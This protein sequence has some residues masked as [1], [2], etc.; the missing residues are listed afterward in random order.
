MEKILKMS[1]LVALVLMVGMI[2]VNIV[3]RYLFSVTY[4]IT[5][6]WPVWLMIWCVF[7]YIG[8]NV[9]ENGHLA[10]DIVPNR[11]SGKKRFILDMFISSA[12]LAFGILFLYA[13]WSDVMMAKMTR[14][15]TITSI[16][17]PLW[18]VKLCLPL[19]MIFFIFHTLEKLMKEIQAQHEGGK[20][21]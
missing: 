11:L 20:K 14:I 8:V 19:G 17:V 4:G 15:S 21:C 18:V 12:M 6:E 9:K 13:C 2:F 3:S 16:P 1:G 10:V 7:V 5:E